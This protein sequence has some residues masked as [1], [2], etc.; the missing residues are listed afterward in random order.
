VTSTSDLRGASPMVET[1]RS[2]G[3]FGC[4]GL[5]PDHA[6]DHAVPIGDEV[7][8]VYEPRTGKPV[9]YCKAVNGEWVLL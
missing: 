1:C 2:K 6:G 9:G 8:F 5:T 4:C 7:W 3:R